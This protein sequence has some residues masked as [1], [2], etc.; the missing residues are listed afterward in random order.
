[1]EQIHDE[2]NGAG[3][4]GDSLALGVALPRA[5]DT[6]PQAMVM[7]KNGNRL[8]DHTGPLPSMNLVVA[9][10]CSVGATMMT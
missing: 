3:A 6:A 7:N 5:A 4:N 8:P 1:M 2:G 9:G 10:I